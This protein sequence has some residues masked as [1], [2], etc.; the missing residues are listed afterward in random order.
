MPQTT[1]DQ[2]AIIK[3]AFRHQDAL[4]SHAFTLVRDWSVAE[5]V[6]QNAFI[7]AMDRWEHFIPG[8]SVYQ[9]VRGIVHL[10]AAGAA[11]SPSRKRKPL[12]APF[13][14][15]P[16]CSGTSGHRRKEA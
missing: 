8:S 15:L 1:M 12:S 14:L 16:T 10:E 7:V 6:V 4:R 2:N 3:A 11:A 13:S 5:D 9:W